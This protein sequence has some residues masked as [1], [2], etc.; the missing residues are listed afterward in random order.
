MKNWTLNIQMN[1]IFGGFFLAII[2]LQSCRHDFP[3]PMLPAQDELL[4]M[5]E[6][7]FIASHNSYRKVTTDTVLGFLQ[8][9]SSLLP[10]E[11]D[12]AKLDY[13]HLPLY[14][15]LNQYH[16]RGLEI[17][18][19][20]DPNG[21]AFSNR[22][23]NFFVGLD[24]V[25]GIAAL[26]QPGFKVLH[27]KDVDY[28]TH[29]Y[30]FRQ[31][32]QAI[33]F[34]SLSNPDHLP[35][36]VNVETKQDAPG[37]DPTLAALGFQPAPVYDV[38]AADALD[39]EIKEVFGENLDGI[40]TPDRLRGNYPTLQTAVLNKAWP[41]LKN[42]RGKV[43]FI[44]EGACKSFYMQNHPSLTGRAMFVYT[45]PGNDECAFIV[46]NDAPNQLQNIEN[47]VRQGYMVRTR[48]DIETA[49]ARSGDYTRMNAALNSGAHI[50]S[51]DYYRP[52]SRA[53][54]PGWSNYHVQLPGGAVARKN[55]V[56][57]A[58]I[59]TDDNIIE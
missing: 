20:Y 33:R 29:F 59:L 4:R 42:S 48:C 54:Q 28:N 13:D 57:A 11:M 16:M 58:H 39:S 14:E 30:T 47:Y 36:F 9:V 56:N 32:L 34:W 41:T 3:S 35:L 19:Y 23:I 52:D 31:A 25:A 27:I 21:G 18:V 45:N 49:E 7:Q 46:Q 24:T 10:P 43:V 50:C 53:G 44:M 12:P 8:S 15:Q 22:F 26:D 51:T 6:I 37:D 2:L 17:D 40:F 55:P 38:A 1:I 5:N